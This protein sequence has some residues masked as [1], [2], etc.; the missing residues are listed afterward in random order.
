MESKV[1]MERYGPLR[2]KPNRLRETL[3]NYTSQPLL[4]DKCILL[5]FIKDATISHNLTIP[6]PTSYEK[7]GEKRF[8]SKQKGARCDRRT[9]P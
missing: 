4:A 5:F 3:A 8:E 6:I 7:N 2:N 1:Y 9:T